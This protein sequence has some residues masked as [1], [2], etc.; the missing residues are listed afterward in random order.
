MVASDFRIGEVVEVFSFGGYYR[1]TVEKVGLSRI[2][3]RYTTGT[4]YTRSKAFAVE[5]KSK[6]TGDP[7]VRKVV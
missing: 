2:T 5:G 3:V 6:F 4:G 1:G 7:L